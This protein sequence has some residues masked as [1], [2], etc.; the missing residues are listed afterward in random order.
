M[1]V[2]MPSVVHTGYAHYIVGSDEA[3]NEYA[4]PIVIGSITVITIQA[5]NI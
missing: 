4:M 1:V 5:Q 2:V 3:I